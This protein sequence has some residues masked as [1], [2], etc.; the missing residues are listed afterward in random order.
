MSG[1]K[2]TFIRRYIA[3]RS[4]KAEKDWKNRVRKRRVVGRIYGIQYKWKG[5]KDRNRHRSRIE[6]SGQARLAYVKDM[7]RNIPS[8]WRGARED[9]TWL[10]CRT[11]DE[12]H[13][14]C[15]YTSSI[16]KSLNHKRSQA[17]TSNY[18]QSQAK[19]YLTALD[20]MQSRAKETKS[21][22]ANNGQISISTFTFYFLQL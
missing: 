14:N 1:L 22:K 15:F 17:I 13:S 18:K 19:S 5:H 20:A 11:W 8:M 10:A 3:E 9:G 16:H 21:R 6:R 7:N 12:S 4:S 2:E